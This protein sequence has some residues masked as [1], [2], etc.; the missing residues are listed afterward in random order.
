MLVDEDHVILHANKKVR[1]VF[2][3]EVEEIVGE[4]CPAV[5]HGAE[6]PYPGCPLE[7]S[8]KR[9][10]VPIERELFDERTGLWIKS[11]IYPLNMR[12]KNGK[13]VFLHFVQDVTDKKLTTN[14]QEELKRK[15]E[16][17]RAIF[18]NSPNVV[19]IVSEDGTVVEANPTMM[20]SFKTNPVGRK[21]EELFPEEV[22]RKWIRCIKQAILNGRQSTFEESWGGKH[23]SVS[24]LPMRVA[25]EKFA[26]IIGRDVTELKNKETFLKILI[27][28]ERLIDYETDK[29]RLLKRVCRKL[30]EVPKCVAVRIDLFDDGNFLFSCGKLDRG[31]AD[32]SVEALA[33]PL[34]TERVVGA[35]TVRFRGNL[36]RE[37][38]SILETLASDISFALK[39]FELDEAKRRAFERIEENIY[40]FAVLVDE[41]K[42]ALTPISLATELQLP[43]EL[44]SEIIT[45]QVEKIRN[46][47]REID[48]G[49]IES[50]K[51]RE[52]LKRYM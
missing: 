12:T 24:I 52:F 9:G 1:E 47:L 28:I 7:E 32:V 17:Y 50:E 14:L 36:T 40:Q 15:E 34:K 43:R 45:R 42:N 22:A 20:E 13:R 5:I 38:V 2:G 23:Y 51:V 27:E 46:I 8:I 49:W 11:S 10:Y 30:L 25:N 31:S 48:R 4:Y 41:I 3:K 18:E 19:G 6:E 29:K 16:K 26:L 33:L 37:E 44:I 35:I 21:I 39:T